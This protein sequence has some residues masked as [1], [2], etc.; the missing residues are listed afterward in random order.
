MIL[1]KREEIKKI[2]Y[3]NLEE[4]VYINGKIIYFKRELLLEK[5]TMLILDIMGIIPDKIAKVKYPSEFRPSLL[6]T[7]LDLSVNMDCTIE[8]YKQMN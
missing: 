7:T 8:I 3:G 4:G 1:K 5:F 6:L 2:Q